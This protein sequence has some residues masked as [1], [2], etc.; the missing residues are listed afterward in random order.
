MITKVNKRLQFSMFVSRGRASVL[1]KYSAVPADRDYYR[2]EYTD[3]T[4][5]CDDEPIRV[6]K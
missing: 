4:P 3:V 1:T 6:S 5:P 2:G